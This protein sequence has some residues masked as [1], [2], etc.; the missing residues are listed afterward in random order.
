MEAL[1]C[2]M[3]QNRTMIKHKIIMLIL[4]I[5]IFIIIPAQSQELITDLVI[6]D[7]ENAQDWS[8]QSNLQ[9]GDLL[10]GDRDYTIMTIPE[11]Y[12]GVD[13]IRS[14]NDSKGYESDPLV[15]FR[16]SDSANVIIA[17]DDRL[18]IRDWLSDWTDTGE[19]MTNNESTPRTFSLFTRKFTYN[20]TIELGPVAQTSGANN[21]IILVKKLGDAGQIPDDFSFNDVF[22]A[23]LNQDVYSEEITIT[24]LS[25]STP[26]SI[27]QGAYSINGGSYQSSNGIINNMDQ[28]RIR[29]KASKNHGSVMSTT[30]TIGAVSTDFNI[31]TIDDPESGWAMVPGILSQ[32]NP[33]V[34]PDRDFNIID[35]GA[36][37][38]G[39]TICTEAFQQA[40]SACSDSGGGRVIVPE[41]EFLTGAIH[42]KSNV[43]LYLTKNAMIKFSQDPE[44]FLPV[45]Y[46]RFE[47]TECYNYSPPVYAFEQ[48]NI[49]ITGQGSLDGQGDYDH[50]WNWTSLDDA[51]ISNLRQQAEDGVSVE[52]RIYGNG[53]YLRPNMIQ[54]YR[55]TNVLFDSVNILNGPMWHIHPVLCENVTVSNVSVNGH[56]PNNDG[57]NPESCT[58]V[59]I[60]NCF[61]NTG[62][63]CIAIKSGRNADGRRVNV[64]TEN[65]VIQ[66]CTMNDGHGGVVIGSEMSGSVRNVFAEDCYMDS[67]NLDRALRI[68]TN[69]MRGGIVENV[70]LRNITV[71]QVADA[72]FRVNFYYGEGDVGDFTPVVHNVEIRNL[73]CEQSNYALRL[74][75]YPRSPVSNIRLVNCEIENASA[76]NYISNVQNLGLNQVTINDDFYQKI[77]YPFQEDPVGIVEFGQNK[78][79]ESL[80]LMQN[81]PN[82]FNPFT[83]IEF[84][85]LE[86]THVKLKVYDI[87]GN[88]VSTLVDEIKSAGHYSVRFDGSNLSSG[89]YVYRLSYANIGLTKKMVLIK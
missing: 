70:Y 61:F 13:W 20:D 63:D 57:C 73:T 41:G 26:I 45:V 53:H 62:D 31:Q 18:T 2:R 56:G 50:W 78:W 15:S 6:Y 4:C 48:E 10:F 40:I 1:D 28:V 3:E 76:S 68:K 16:I 32:I 14:A 29:F 71:G 36:I 43:N 51:D 17:F 80:L 89:I 52:E 34:F 11:K 83:R 30:L 25:A 59:L 75:G 8:I 12:I 19:D 47:G 44:D 42:L 22:D 54:P 65:V 35:F 81:Y 82:P 72:V 49:A 87:L 27:T 55:C 74:Q 85:V 58:D 67:P 46:T 69:S 21:Y 64:P 66:N 39:E 7:S 77:W 88:L 37:G 84:R 86:K 79:P 23:D 38:D 60:K 24:G 9:I 33:P 5:F